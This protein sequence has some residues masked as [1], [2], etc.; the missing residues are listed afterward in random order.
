MH[1]TVL[2]ATLALLLV[3]VVKPAYAHIICHN[4][5]G[6]EALGAN[7]D[8]ATGTCSITTLEGL[9]L[10]IQTTQ[11]FGIPL[12]LLETS[13]AIAAHIAHGDGVAELIIEPRL[14]LAST[15]Q[16]HTGANVGCVGRRIIEQP[17]E[18]GN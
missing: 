17:E 12:P 8:P 1:R 18:P 4:I 16:N 11:F 10:T 14:H 9:T 13:A 6:P 15:G 5:G 3:A 7:C 2:A